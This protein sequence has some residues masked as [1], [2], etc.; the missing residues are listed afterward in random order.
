MKVNFGLVI[1]LSLLLFSCNKEKSRSNRLIK[2]DKWE[3]QEITIDGDH[4][5]LLGTW[6]ITGDDIYK[7]VPSASW[8]LNEQNAVFEWQFQSKGKKFQLNYVQLC[9]ECDG[10]QLSDL[11]Y[12]SYNLSGSYY[13]KKCSRKQM[14]FE[15]SKTIGYPDRTIR[16]K[17]K[18]I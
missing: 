5:S 11:D 15:S 1:I 17:I 8:F 2:G 16:I 9:E 12:F 14:E 10:E 13:V 7:E 6:T 3:V 4:T 18:R